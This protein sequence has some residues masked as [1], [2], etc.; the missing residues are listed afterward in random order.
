[1]YN[2]RLLTSDAPRRSV[3]RTLL[4]QEVV[5]LLLG[6]KYTLKEGKVWIESL[7]RFKYDNT[8]KL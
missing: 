4:L 6:S 1:M 3:D 8:R 5:N 2:N 7:S